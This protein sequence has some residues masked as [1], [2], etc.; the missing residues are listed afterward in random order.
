MKSE[1]AAVDI[2]VCPNFFALYTSL[3]KS[4]YNDREKES[5]M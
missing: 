5:V 2:R 4:L 3:Y 1:I